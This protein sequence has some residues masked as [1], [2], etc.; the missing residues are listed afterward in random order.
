MKIM[1]CYTSLAITTYEHYSGFGYS[2]RDCKKEIAAP[3]NVQKRNNVLIVRDSF[4][5][6]HDASRSGEMRLECEIKCCGTFIS[7][8]CSARTIFLRLSHNTHLFL[9]WVSSNLWFAV[10]FMNVVFVSEYSSEN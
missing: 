1:G 3:Y 7:I 2:I 8:H 5:F 4:D 9:D 6:R 10:F